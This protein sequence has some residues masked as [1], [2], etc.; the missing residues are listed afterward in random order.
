[1]WATASA[2]ARREVDLVVGV[3]SRE[4]ALLDLD[5][6]GLRL[7]ELDLVAL[8]HEDQVVGGEEHVAQR[9]PVRREDAD[10]GPTPLADE[11]LVAGPQGGQRPRWDWGGEAAGR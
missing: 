11:D 6:A 7:Q 10:P 3:R 2:P 5:Q 1:M 9:N 4:R 8:Q